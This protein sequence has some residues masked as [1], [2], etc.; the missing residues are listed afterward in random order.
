MSRCIVV[1]LAL[2]LLASAVHLMGLWKRAGD[3]AAVLFGLTLV[4]VLLSV[5]ND[6]DKVPDPGTGHR[7]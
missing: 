3:L 1:S 7:R 5:I 4:L 2:A 6:S